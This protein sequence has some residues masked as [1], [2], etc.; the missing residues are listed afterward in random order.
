MIRK[1][2]NPKHEIIDLTGPKG[3]AF[4][5]M[6]RAGKL[7]DQLGLDGP[8]ILGDM[9]SGDYEHLIKVFDKHFGDHVILER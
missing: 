4:Y 6:G 1:K 8:A 5:L 9:Q 3:N 2:K 7:A